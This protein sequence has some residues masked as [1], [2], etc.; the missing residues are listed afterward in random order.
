MAPLHD[1]RALW[2]SHEN[3]A[4]FERLC[5][6]AVGEETLVPNKTT[7]QVSHIIAAAK[8]GGKWFTSRRLTVGTRIR[9]Y[10]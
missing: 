10:E 8:K 6:L 2:R 5:S 9:R 1:T 4:V 7:K 3:Y